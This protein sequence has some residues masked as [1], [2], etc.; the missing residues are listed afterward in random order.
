MKKNGKENKDEAILFMPFQNTKR[1]SSIQDDLRTL[2]YHIKDYCFIRDVVIVTVEERSDGVSS[3][4]DTVIGKLYTSLFA[5]VVLT[6]NSNSVHFEAGFAHALAKPVLYISSKTTD[7]S[8]YPRLENVLTYDKFNTKFLDSL[9]SR[10]SQVIKEARGTEARLMT[11]LAKSR[12][13]LERLDFREDLYSRLQINAALRFF[14]WLENWNYEGP[15]RFIGNQN[16]LEIGTFIL[17]NLQKG[18]FATLYFPGHESW[19]ADLDPGTND[20]Y[21]E[22][23]KD[24]VQRG[25]IIER[26]YILTDESQVEN[27]AFR[28]LA[29]RDILYGIDTKYIVMSDEELLENP[30]ILDFAVWDDTL[31]ADVNYARREGLPPQIHYCD[32]YRK[33]LNYTGSLSDPLQQAKTLVETLRRDPRLRPCPALPSEKSLLLESWE[34]LI[35]PAREYCEKSGYNCFPYHGYWQILRLC[36]MV[37]TPTWHAEFY[38]QAFNLWYNR[39]RTLFSDRYQPRILISGMADYGMLYSIIQSI[40][41]EAAQ[42]CEFDVLDRCY[43]PINS[44]MWLQRRLKIEKTYKIDLLIHSKHENIIDNS[45]DKGAYD[46]VAADAFLTRDK[47]VRETRKEYSSKEIFREWIDLLRPGGEIITT[48]RVRRP[49]GSDITHEAR[50][51]FV[52]RCIDSFYDRN[53]LIKSGGPRKDS[54]VAAANAYSEFIESYPFKNETEIM[55][56]LDF[57]SDQLESSNMIFANHR[58]EIVELKRY[59]MVSKPLYAR[60][61]VRKC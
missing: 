49:D 37:S 21:F 30:K 12:S 5:V 10:L 56:L 42:L 50:K 52:A 4:Y 58:F 18:G 45:L 34:D 14:S 51:N 15:L 1:D 27:E 38:Y 6:E 7:L 2:A 8:F 46:L 59:E 29:R 33:P 55:E 9:K 40:G 25:C 61:A 36:N 24:A 28:R 31:Y 43:S 13:G 3:I 22:A 32:Y 44:C 41:V 57:F 39:L 11:E 48:A 20:E 35:D 16:V 54:L 23:A 53:A 26:V 60:I 17:N 19:I 47:F